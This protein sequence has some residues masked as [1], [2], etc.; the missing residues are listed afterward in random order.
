MLFFDCIPLYMEYDNGG[1]VSDSLYYFDVNQDV[2]DC[3][4]NELFST[5]E[6]VLNKTVFYGLGAVI[7]LGA[8]MVFVLALGVSLFAVF[9][10]KSKKLSK[11]IE[12]A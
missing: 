11:E 3:E 12:N 10:V 7:T 8:G 1:N 6:V 5:Y 4:Y 9:K 2:I